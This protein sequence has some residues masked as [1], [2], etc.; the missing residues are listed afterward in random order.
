M[1]RGAVRPRS[2][3]CSSWVYGRGET[4]WLEQLRAR[5]CLSSEQS[6]KWFLRKIVAK[7]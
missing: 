5:G 2:S 7:G 3:K 6:L 4:V 1:W